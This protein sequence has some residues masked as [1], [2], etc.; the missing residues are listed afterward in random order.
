MRTNL[1]KTEDYVPKCLPVRS[2]ICITA[3]ASVQVIV[4]TLA[5]DKVRVM[6]KSDDFACLKRPSCLFNSVWQRLG[7]VVHMVDIWSVNA[8][9]GT[10]TGKDLA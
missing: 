7:A 6:L 2:P 9:S 5:C 8:T 3:C 1:G 4:C 10:G